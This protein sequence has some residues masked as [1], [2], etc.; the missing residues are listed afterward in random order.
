MGLVW[1]PLHWMPKIEKSDLD[2]YIAGAVKTMRIAQKMPQSVLAVK[3]GVSNAFIGQCEVPTHKSKY[4]LSHL[5]KLAII[6]DCS[7]KDFLPQKPI[8]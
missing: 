3:L 4:N 6:F 2:Q 7:P 8:I 5:N 1:H